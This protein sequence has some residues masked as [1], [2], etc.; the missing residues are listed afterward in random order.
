MKDIRKKQA[1][2]CATRKDSEKT[3]PRENKAKRQTLGTVMGEGSKN[4]LASF[5]S[6]L[7]HLVLFKT[8]DM[9]RRIPQFDKGMLIM[10]I[11]IDVGSK[12]LGIVNQGENDVNVSS[13][14]SEYSVGEIEELAIPEFLKLLD[15]YRAPV[16]FAV[17]GQLTEIPDSILKKLLNSSVNHD[18]GAHGY[19]HRSFGNLSYKEA[20]KEMKM[21]SDGMRKFGLTP[22]SFVFPRNNVAHLGLLRKYGYECFRE[23][24]NFLNDS[25]CLKK[26]CGLWEVHPSLAI[27]RYTNIVFLKGILDVAVNGRLPMHLWFHMRDFGTEYNQIKRSLGEVF[28]PLLDY[29]KAKEEEGVLTFETMFSATRKARSLF[30]RL[31]DTA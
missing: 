22:K 23:Y 19:Y 11:D 16:T 13:R 2:S 24:S 18:I 25:M 3:M 31:G 10:S 4:A 7:Y 20:E 28:L 5:L 21:T 9:P 26:K 27:D 6:G 12:E 1:R 29:A 14:M 30:S 15:S 8:R 17:R